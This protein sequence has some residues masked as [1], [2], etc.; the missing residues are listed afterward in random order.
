M[1]LGETR[2]FDLQCDNKMWQEV[3]QPKTLFNLVFGKLNYKNVVLE[4][5]FISVA[6]CLLQ[7]S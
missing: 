1:L 6:V 3:V 7:G 4:T 5:Q 2:M